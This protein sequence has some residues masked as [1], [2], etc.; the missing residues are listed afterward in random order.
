[1]KCEL[2]RDDL[3]VSPAFTDEMLGAAHVAQIV[4]K[5]I[6]RNG[7]IQP[8]RFWKVG[9]IIDMPDAYMLVRM[10]C[11]KPADPACALRANRS[12]AEQVDAQKAY[13]RV[14]LGILPEDYDKFD[15]GIILGYEPNGDYK[16]GPNFHLLPKS[17][18]GE[19]EEE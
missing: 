3:E 13:E 1:M 17:E 5:D 8:V 15:A 16:P 4:M 12:A 2:I 9:A 10:G 14:A 18:D 7:R 6:M 19:D 11:A